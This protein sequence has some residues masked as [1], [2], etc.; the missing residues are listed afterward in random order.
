MKNFLEETILILQ[1]NNKTIEDVIFICTG[2]GN[3]KDIKKF[4]KFMD[5]EYD[6]GYG[7]NVIPLNLKIVGKD[8]WLERREYDGSEWWEFKTYPIPNETT[9]DI[10]LN[11]DG[12]YII[13]ERTNQ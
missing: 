9:K 12:E 13:L 3:V 7:L 2:A 8:F 10:V 4:F 5:F 1:K 11:S 6:A